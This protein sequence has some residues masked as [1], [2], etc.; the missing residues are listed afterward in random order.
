MIYVLS[1]DDREKIQEVVK[2]VLGEIYEIFEGEELDAQGI[3][4]IFQG[5]TLFSNERKILI[6]DLTPAPSRNEQENSTDTADSTVPIKKTPDF[7]ELMA[8]YVDTP[9]TIVIWESYTSRK[10]SYKEFLKLKNVQA[11]KYEKARPADAGMV[12]DILKM[13]YYD[14]ATAVKMVEKI[15]KDNDPY[16]FFGLLASQ[17]LKK[18]DRKVLKELSDLDMQMKTT[19]IEPWALISSFLLRVSSL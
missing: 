16:M 2:K 7:Y 10:K 5:A 11:K 12:F 8:E 9:H 13:A 14:G 15:K 4:N 1:G 19:A 6:K 18:G 3:M 17:A